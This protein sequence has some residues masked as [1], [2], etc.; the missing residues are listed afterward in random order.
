MLKPDLRTRR[1][2]P[3]FLLA[4]A[5]LI[6]SACQPPPDPEWRDPGEYSCTQ[7]TS[8]NDAVVSLGGVRASSENLLVDGSWEATVTGRSS[9]TVAGAAGST[10]TVRLR[11]NGYDGPDGYGT[12]TCRRVQT[13]ITDE[14]FQ[15][16]EINGRWEIV[17]SDAPGTPAPWAAVSLRGDKFQTSASYS[18][19]DRSLADLAE[20]FEVVRIPLF[21]K[22]LEPNGPRSQTSLAAD[23]ALDRVGDTIERLGDLGVGVVLDP[24]HTVGPE[25][26]NVPVWAYDRALSARDYQS[27]YHVDDMFEVVSYKTGGVTQGGAYLARMLEWSQQFDNVVALELMNEPHPPDGSP[28][29]NTNQIIDLFQDEWIPQLRAI[30]PDKPLVLSGFFGAVLSDADQVAELSVDES[31]GRNLIWS[32]HSYYTGLPEA[33]D[34]VNGFDR[35]ADDDGFGDIGQSPSWREGTKMGTST[36]AWKTGGCYAARDTIEVNPTGRYAWEERAAWSSLPNCPPA[37][38]GVRAMARANLV[39]HVEEQDAVAQAGRMPL[40]MG[41]TGHAQ[42][43]KNPYVGGANAYVGW[44]NAK[45]L[46]CDRKAAF[47]GLGTAGVATVWWHFDKRAG[48]GFGLYN[49][50]THTWA[51]SAGDGRNG[52]QGIARPFD[53]TINA[54]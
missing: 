39:E 21:W 24:M 33:G 18:I 26:Y 20:R 3:I 54:C 1:R 11:G 19:D 30:D 36:A 15:T 29:R 16:A 27:E 4:L 43:H 41:E 53:P 12:A 17:R 48:I 28:Y 10:L 23:T 38:A 32:A 46:V 50:N 51:D 25:T 22:E 37:D 49:P 34:T 6:A 9:L 47:D 40:F 7:T 35:D 42:I 44:G 52:D 14:W 2:A 13:P 45:D 5:A 31:N 8:G